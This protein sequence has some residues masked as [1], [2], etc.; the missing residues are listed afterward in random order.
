MQRA[1]LPNQV[2]VNLS[3]TAGIFLLGD[4]LFEGGTLK[5]AS[6]L[7]LLILDAIGAALIAFAIYRFLRVRRRSSGL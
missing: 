7:H 3:L 4:G 2:W 1:E 6:T 5:T